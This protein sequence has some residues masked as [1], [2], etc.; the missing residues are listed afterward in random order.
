MEV[1]KITQSYYKK[2]FVS[3]ICKIV[4]S[5]NLVLIGLILMANLVGIDWANG[6]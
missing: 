1:N 6:L 5:S 3:S 2:I 4:V